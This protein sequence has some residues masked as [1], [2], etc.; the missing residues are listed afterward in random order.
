MTQKLLLAIIVLLCA[1]QAQALNK[2]NI[3]EQYNVNFGADA[4]YRLQNIKSQNVSQLLITPYLNKNL[5]DNEYGKTDFT[6]SMN[7]VKFPHTKPAEAAARQ[8]IATLFNSYDADYNELYELYISYILPNEYNDITIGFGQIPIAKFDSPIASDLQ[9]YYFLNSATSQN[10]TFI[11][12]TAGIGAYSQTYLSPN[13]IFSLGFVDASNPTADGIH[14]N[15]FA[16]NSYFASVNYVP[17][18][19]SRYRGS[20]SLL[21]YNKPSV[22]KSAYSGQGWSLY[23]AQDI[24]DKHSL[25]LRLNGSTGNNITTNRSYTVGVLYN[26]PFNRSQNDG[27]GAAYSVNKINKKATDDRVYN[28]YEHITEIYYNYSIND[29]FSVLSDAQLYFKRGYEDKNSPAAIISFGFNLSF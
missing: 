14:F 4:A 25:F 29:N 22:K 9:R 16:E 6:F 11:Y 12:P 23:L 19:Y 15:R 18:I 2:Q 26:N 17:Q 5:S 7:I 28:T 20:Y 3:E 8:K 1:N 27:L 24:S 13:L 10:T 21:L